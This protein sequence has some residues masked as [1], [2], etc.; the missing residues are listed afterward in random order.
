MLLA[1][2]A[3]FRILADPTRRALFERLARTDELTVREL[4]ARA[5]VSQPAVSQH[6]AV[7]KAAGLVAERRDGRL[8]HY[9]ARPQALRRLVDWLAMYGT[10]W[11]DRLDR[12]EILLKEVDA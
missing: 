11:S 8:T 6:L 2:G 10:F 12:L 1:S 9:R 5:G 4:T 7:L 3:L